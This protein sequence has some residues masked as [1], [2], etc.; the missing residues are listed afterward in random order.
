M[1]Y[2][3]L[4]SVLFETACIHPTYSG[5]PPLSK[6]R[7][8]TYVGRGSL[9]ARNIFSYIFLLYMRE[10]RT[11]KSSF[12]F[13]I[14]VLPIKCFLERT[15]FV[16]IFKEIRVFL[17]QT[18]AGKSLTGESQ[19]SLTNVGL[20]LSGILN[21]GRRNHLLVIKMHLLHRPASSLTFN[22]YVRFLYQSKLIRSAHMA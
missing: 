17:Y 12:L 13:H 7:K 3:K 22:F 4:I 18:K 21:F 6:S 10:T 11:Q 9:F 5:F 16:S 14:L 15:C 8:L 19:P 20:H 1:S 2:F